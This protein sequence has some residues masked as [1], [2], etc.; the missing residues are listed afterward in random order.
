MAC[1]SRKTKNVNP[2]NQMAFFELPF[3]IG[4]IKITPIKLPHD[5][6]T[7]FG[8]SFEQNGKNLVF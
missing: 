7:C 6:H 1:N 2:T 8:F 5:S 4:E 3:E